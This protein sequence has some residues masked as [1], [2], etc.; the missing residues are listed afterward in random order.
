MK[1]LFL[2][3]FLLFIIILGFGIIGCGGGGG[4]GSDFNTATSASFSPMLATDSA[5][6][7][8]KLKWVYR[9]NDGNPV[10][11]YSDG[12]LMS[13]DSDDITLIVDPSN[14]K[15]M[16]RLSG[17]LS[18]DVAGSY[19]A[20]I[21]E[22]LSFIGGSTYVNRTNL[23]TTMK[24]SVEGESVSVVVD[25]LTTFTPA[26]EWFLDRD[27]LDQLAIGY[28]YSTESFE[29]YVTGTLQISGYG[30]TPIDFYGDQADRWKVT[31]KQ[32]SI[33]VQ[34]T[35]YYNIVEVTRHTKIPDAYGTGTEDAT[36]IYWVA[37][38]IGWVKAFGHFRFQDE[39][40]DV[41]LVDTNLVVEGGGGAGPETI[42]SRSNESI[43]A[44]EDQLIEFT[45]DKAG[46][47]EIAL[48]EAGSD[49]SWEIYK[50]DQFIEECDEFYNSED[51]IHSLELA[52]NTTYDLMITEW[53]DEDSYYDLNITYLYSS[54]NDYTGF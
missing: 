2:C 27:D 34:G 23:K 31:G 35:T 15:M 16:A 38:G 22:D 26:G 10:N 43:P 20:D 11:T 41:E 46:V 25:L 13:L 18:G 21:N 51:E 24:I 6:N 42:L 29:A 50:D 52:A 9:V 8:T 49:L 54:D 45:T 1:K 36:Y 33:T 7:T 3:K 4:G 12:M 40:L 44:G 19:V 5:G 14:N 53:D 47:Y 39:P 30:T 48:T 28:E 32:D 17:R 37:K